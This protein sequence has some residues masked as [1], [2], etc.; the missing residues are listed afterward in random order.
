MTPADAETAVPAA[1]AVTICGGSA[2]EGGMRSASLP[3][4]APDKLALAGFTRR[5]NTGTA[6][7]FPV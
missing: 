6:L 7:N 1:Y 3:N 5:V 4:F 2:V